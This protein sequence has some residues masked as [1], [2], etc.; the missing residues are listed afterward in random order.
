VGAHAAA[1]EAGASPATA[2]PVV[3][4]QVPGYYRQKLGSFEVTALSDGTAELPFT[5]LL[6]RIPK[7]EIKA[8][9]ER[10]YLHDPVET[11]FNA[12]LINTGTHLVLIDTGAGT[13]FGPT[14]G[15]MNDNLRAAG[16]KPED[17]NAVL[18]THLHPDHVGGI[19]F[20]HER[21]FSNA[22]VYV[23]A[24]EVDE[25]LNE[26]KRNAASKEMQG[27]YDGARLSLAPY[28]LRARVRE[29]KGDTQIVPGVRALS[30]YGHT[31][32]HTVY[33]V[34]SG[35]AT[36]LVIGDLIHQA[37]IQFEQPGVTIRFDSDQDAAAAQ[38]R[39]VWE[40]AARHGYLI[41]AAHISFPG[42]GR[43]RAEGSAFRWL[44]V[45]YTVNR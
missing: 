26:D 45:S 1:A 15:K 27:F 12:F 43:V 6:A 28:R 29:F 18:I 24:R 2:A 44:P 10:H 21:V 37:A 9:L 41:A 22:D 25:W 11:S 3:K 32:G 4:P 38:R 16:Y 40:Q 23:D 35:G 17:V 33:E 39:K 31:P 13:L 20:E 42:L 34:T 5:D 8:S 36:M 14:L 30:T 19:S 7:E